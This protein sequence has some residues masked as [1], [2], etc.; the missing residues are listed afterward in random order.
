[1]VIAAE[2]EELRRRIANY[3]GTGLDIKGKCVILADDGLATG[4]SMRAAIASARAGGA[5]QIVV[6]VPVA[7][8][9]AVQT[10]EQVERV[11]VYAVAVPVNFYAVGPWY[12]DF[13]PTTDDE[14]RAAFE[15]ISA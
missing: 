1:M 14:V 9:D 8:R 15:G 5:A 11:P 10:I 2:T 3:P 7:S 12:R 6:A 4:S 13:S